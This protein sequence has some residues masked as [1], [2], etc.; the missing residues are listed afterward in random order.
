MRGAAQ[1]VFVRVARDRESSVARDRE[2]SVAR[3]RESGVARVE[4]QW[5]VDGW[6]TKRAAVMARVEER[7][8]GWAYAQVGFEAA[9]PPIASS[10]TVEAT[11]VARDATGRERWL[12]DFGKNL[13]LTTGC[14]PR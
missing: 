13:V 2:S 6:R 1:A 5:S 14:A 11:V 8:P 7:Q 12:T 4:V 9:L 10:R 3:D